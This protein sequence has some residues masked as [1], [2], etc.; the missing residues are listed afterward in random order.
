MVKSPPSHTK[1]RLCV[2]DNSTGRAG[3][4]PCKTLKLERLLVRPCFDDKVDNGGEMFA[5]ESAGKCPCG[6]SIYERMTELTDVNNI[7]RND[8]TLTHLFCE[9]RYLFQVFF[10]SII[11]IVSRLHLSQKSCVV[12]FMTHVSVYIICHFVSCIC[13]ALNKSI[14]YS[15]DITCTICR[16]QIQYCSLIYSIFSIV[17]N[18]N[19]KKIEPYYSAAHRLGQI[20]NDSV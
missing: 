19:Y 17:S 18:N 15:S 14:R 13:H 11:K 9:A 4:S 3:A 20:F 16:Q 1:L 5:F 8:K 7:A 2:G 12:V 6:V 10:F